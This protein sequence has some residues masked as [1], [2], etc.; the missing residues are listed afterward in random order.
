MVYNKIIKLSKKEVK[1]K[2][3]K[4]ITIN[5]YDPASR[6]DMN[7][8][9]ARKFFEFVAKKAAENGYVVKYTSA[10]STDKESEDFVSNL[11]QQY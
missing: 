10:I 11:F 5:T 4:T 2:T 7:N 9:E 1:M 3:T 6:F 8:A